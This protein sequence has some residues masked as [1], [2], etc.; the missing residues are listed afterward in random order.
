MT[1]NNWLVENIENLTFER[2]TLEVSDVAEKHR[3]LPKGTPFPGAYRTERTPYLTEPMNSISESSSTEFEVWLKGHQL[4]YTLAVEN[5]ILYIIKYAPGPILYT[6]ASNDLG[7]EWSENRFDQMCQ[8]SDIQHL[9]FSQ[10][11]KKGS[12]KTGDKTLLK[13][14]PGGRIKIA[15]YG[16]SAAFRS[17]SY[18]YF[19]GDEIDEALTDLK[20]QGNAIKQAE[21]R[22]SAYKAKRKIIL[23]S[24][25]VEEDQS[26]VYKA[27]LLGDQRKYFVP[28]PSCSFMQELKF[29]HLSYE[30]DEDGVLNIESVKHKCQNK[31]CDSFFQNHHKVEMYSSGK[32]EWRAT[33]KAKR[34]N[35]ISR[36]MSCM[37]SP[38]GMITWADVVQQYLD[39]TD[40]EDPGMMKTFETLWLGMPYKERGEAPKFSQIITH[41]GNYKSKDV[42]D[43]VVFLTLGGDVQGDRIELEVVGYGRKRQTWSIDYIVIEGETDDPNG[44]AWEKFRERFMD[45]EFIYKK[46]N[47]ERYGPQIG[48]I[49][50]GYRQD[51]VEAFCMTCPGLHPIK[52]F[53]KLSTGRFKIRDIP[54]SGL[55][56]IDI[57][58]NYYKD[59]I[60]SSLK[61]E[62]SLRG[63]DLPAGYPSFPRDY[64]DSFFKMLNAEYKRAKKI[65]NRIEYEYHCPPGR[66]NEAL[67][68]RVYSLCASEVIYFLTMKNILKAP[69][70][71]F[72]KKTGRPVTVAEKMEFFYNHMEHYSKL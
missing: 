41:R 14:F 5:G 33:A 64:P 48:F 19:F 50:S 1:D 28:C 71:D 12:K 36:Q 43:D 67:D 53:D 47:G 30:V 51:V 66:R 72:E 31:S 38:A 70:E 46:K 68:T 20:N 23:F 7:K 32:C 4:G 61:I 60:Y 56:S 57:G 13:E 54:G 11:A 35:Y 15:G 55:F 21:G 2:M 45:G 59:W 65:G 3:I 22:T 17:S 58:V 63:D 29:K 40:S 34:N 37:Y 42:P 52:G 62:H 10:T 39:A 6:T 8:Q 27:Y 18:R 49:D 69:I 16:S 44:G 25:P 24:T 9:I 26:N